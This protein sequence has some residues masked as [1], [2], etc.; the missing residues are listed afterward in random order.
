[1]PERKPRTKAGK[2]RKVHRVMGEY[3]RGKLK[4]SSG[5]KVTKRRQAV[6]IALRKA[7]VA[8]RRRKTKPK[9]KRYS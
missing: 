9:R 2:K 1:M 6:A 8:K 5:T 4:S 7:G 3:K